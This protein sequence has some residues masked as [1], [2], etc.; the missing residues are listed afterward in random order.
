MLD[1]GLRRWALLSLPPKESDVI[2]TCVRKGLPCWGSAKDLYSGT[3]ALLGGVFLLSSPTLLGL[4]LNTAFYPF[5][6]HSPVLLGVVW[7]Q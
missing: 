2:D 4:A 6:L 3:H 1:R 7:S 5:P